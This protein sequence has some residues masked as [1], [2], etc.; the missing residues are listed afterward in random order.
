[1]TVDIPFE[2]VGHFARIPVELSGGATGRF[3]V[4]TG[5]GITVVHPSLVD[6]IGLQAT[7]EEQVGH[8]MS[9]QEVRAP[10][11][12]VPRLEIGDHV[13][14]DALAG[15]ADLGDAEGENGFDGIIGLDLLGDLPLTVDPFA[16]VIRLS[17]PEVAT[18]TIVPVRLNRDG[19]AVDMRV[20]LRLPDGQVIEVEVDTG[21]GSTILDSRFMT[22][23]GVDGHESDAR[24]EEGTDQ[25]GHRFVRRFVPIDGALALASGTTHERP[26][27][28]FQD[29]LELDGLIGTD[30][31][32]RYVQ[33]Y[34][35]RT[36]T[37]ALISP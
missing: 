25:T 4:D 32:D 19:L 8:R 1:M 7:G 20:E 35:T 36:S 27:V 33:T 14:A 17:A 29:D 2:R 13:W 28:M 3:L 24:T 22:A 37:I 9:G 18:A 34:D 30:F 16:C 11:V 21:S 10:L 31:L 23:C 15:A 26:T 12:R 6:R 5:V